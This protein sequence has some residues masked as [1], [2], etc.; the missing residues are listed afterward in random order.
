MTV[1]GVTLAEDTH[2]FQ[3]IQLSDQFWSE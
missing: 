1:A 2:T 3:R